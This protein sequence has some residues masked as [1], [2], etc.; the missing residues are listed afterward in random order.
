MKNYIFALLSA[1]LFLPTL[2][3]Y[4]ATEIGKPAP[5]FT[6]TAID[7]AT[8]KPSDYLG[9]I[10]VMEWNNPGCPF[11]H[12]HYDSG[13]M[14]ALQEYAAKKGVVWLTI[15]SGAAGKQGNMSVD[16]AKKYITSQKLSATHYILDP[17]GKIGKLYGA[18]TTP[19]MF[20]IDAKGDIAYKGAIDDK[21]DTEIE[22]I[23]GANNYVRYAIDSLLAGKA[24]EISLTKSYGCSVKYAE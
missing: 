2:N 15:N 17:E 8:V 7:G 6:A 1:L 24:V 14:Q 13:S 9:K 4:A 3:S 19:Q 10:V 22:S 23:K 21:S 12:K 16:E 5:D 20:V 11:V 18:K